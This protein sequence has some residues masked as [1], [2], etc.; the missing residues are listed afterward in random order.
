[1]YIGGKFMCYVNATEVRNN[2]S[3]YLELSKI[4]DVYVTKNNQIIAVISNPQKNGI[5][6]LI[7]LSG[8]LKDKDTGEDYEDMIG[9]EILKHES[10]SR[11]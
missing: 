3:H 8:C 5:E 2:F 10:S 6:N 11:H 7:K 4:E 9:E 1:M